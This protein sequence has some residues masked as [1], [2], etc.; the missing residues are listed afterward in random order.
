MNLKYFALKNIWL[1]IGKTF[2]TT[3]RMDYV[4]V[5]KTLM[6]L[7]CLNFIVSVCK[8]A[9]DIYIPKILIIISIN[10][11]PWNQTTA[12][13][14]PENQQGIWLAGETPKD[15]LA[16]NLWWAGNNLKAW[17]RN[18]KRPQHVSLLLAKSNNMA[19]VCKG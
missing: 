1:N 16:R 10:V 3:K 5:T 8:S 9:S 11:E 13:L 15:N 14:K 19:T 12:V 17:D 4:K 7:K 18:N 2:Y 6:Q